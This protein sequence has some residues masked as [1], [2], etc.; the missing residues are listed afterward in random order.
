MLVSTQTQVPYLHV[1]YE[2]KGVSFVFLGVFPQLYTSSSCTY[3]N[4]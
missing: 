2:A 4:A 1:L 3:L